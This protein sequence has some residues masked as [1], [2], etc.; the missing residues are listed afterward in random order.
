MVRT[1][2]E[3]TPT[4]EYISVNVEGI[5]VGR[6]AP[7]IF[8]LLT[9]A[10]VDDISQ[11][12]A[13]PSYGR[14]GR[15][16]LWFCSATSQPIIPWQ[17]ATRSQQA[18]C[19]AR[20]VEII[21]AIEHFR[22]QLPQHIT[23]SL[24]II[25]KILQ[26]LTVLPSTDAIYCVNQQ[27]LIVYWGYYDAEHRAI[28]VNKLY[29]HYFPDTEKALPA[30]P[31]LP[32]VAKP[33]SGYGMTRLIGLVLLLLIGA[34]YYEVRQPS[35]S[36]FPTPSLTKLDQVRI[37]HE[38][39]V[40]VIQSLPMMLASD[41]PPPIAEKPKIVRKPLMIPS[42]SRLRGD[43]AFLNGVWTTTLPDTARHIQVT[44]RFKDGRA[45]T[46]LASGAMRCKVTSKAAFTAKGQ[47]TIT[48]TR[49]RCTNAL[50][51]YTP[52]LVCENSTP[53]TQCLWKKNTTTR[54]PITLLNGDQ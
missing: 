1:A 4:Q 17:K 52:T 45:T 41:I 49:K 31:D 15:P 44:F 2:L 5:P 18:A 14:Q 10:G 13:Q 24:S 54:L 36:P 51:A 3:V 6:Y 19:V 23:Y 32:S 40:N 11:C 22:S 29:Q 20:L 34:G 53:N 39:L 47:L 8:Q 37:T 48:S 43:I 9:E 26:N 28:D 38:R 50:S 7:Q 46:I 16:P 42:S 21:K 12:F 25:D 27:P 35:A 33:I 30:S